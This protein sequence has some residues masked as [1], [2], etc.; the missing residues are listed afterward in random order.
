MSLAL[1]LPGK[2]WIMLR[3]SLVIMS[4]SSPQAFLFDIGNVLVTFDFEPAFAE[5]RKRSSRPTLEG[6]QQIE[7]L[8]QRLES[9]QIDDQSFIDG[10]MEA[11]A[12]E[13][14]AAD[15]RQLWNDV[16]SPNPPM[17]E[18]VEQLAGRFPL[19]LLSNTSGMHMEHLR[20]TYEVLRHFD[21]GIYS[22]SA[23]CMK[24]GEEIFQQAIERFDLAPAATVYIDDLPDNV[25]TGVRLG[26]DTMAYSPRRHDA[27]LRGL[28]ERGIELVPAITRK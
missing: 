25:V 16:F 5:A 3:H 6:F 20:S 19:Y 2:A 27:F 22:H 1:V 21:D 4:S 13:G 18:V 12:F 28:A 10:A 9:G 11:I 24:P 7:R 15:F 8:K 14:D 26:F 23:G 17:W